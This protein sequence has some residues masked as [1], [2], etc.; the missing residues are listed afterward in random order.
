[1]PQ[2]WTVVTDYGSDELP[3]PR[4]LQVQV[5]HWLDVGDSAHHRQRKPWSASAPRLVGGRAAFDVR[6]VDDDLE[7]LLRR[8]V[9]GRRGAVVDLGG[10]PT[11]LALQP[12]SGH[13]RAS[14]EELWDSATSSRRW[15]VG[16]GSPTTFRNKNLYQ[17]VPMP[18]PVLGHLRRVW[19]EFAPREPIVDLQDDPLLVA[20]LE[21]A[22]RSVEL[23]GRPVIGF[24]GRV[25]YRAVRADD[26]LA[27]MLDRLFRLLPFCGIGAH[28]T[29]GFGSAALLGERGRG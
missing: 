18:K 3:E 12:A 9:E 29:A 23:D 14:W 24:E 26:T 4:D 6:L 5:A 27:T 2:V 17:P 7:P 1:M 8:A 15:S 21:G 28:T 13:H 10:G 19:R 25:V 20:R 22:T 11:Q 16:F